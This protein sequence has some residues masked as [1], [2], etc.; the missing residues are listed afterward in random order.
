MRRGACTP[1]SEGV[2][3]AI[4]RA[5]RRAF[6]FFMTVRL[7]PLLS[8]AWLVA[9]VCP[10]GGRWTLSVVPG[11]DPRSLPDDPFVMASRRWAEARA[12]R[13]GCGVAKYEMRLVGRYL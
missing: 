10:A 6:F 3:S 11:L 7:L 1:K 12:R 8:L 2:V 9:L 5:P 13:V 4:S